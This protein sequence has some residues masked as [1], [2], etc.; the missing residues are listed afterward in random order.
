MVASSAALDNEDDEILFEGKLWHCRV[1]SDAKETWSQAQAKLSLTGIALQIGAERTFVELSPEHYVGDST[2]RQHGF[3]LS[4]LEDTVY[5]AAV[6]EATK[7]KWMQSLATALRKLGTR[8]R[9]GLSGGLA[10]RGANAGGP[11]SQRPE[12]QAPSAALLELRALEEQCQ[13]ALAWLDDCVDLRRKAKK[14]ADQSLTDETER[15]EREKAEKARLEREAKERR[16]EEEKRKCEQRKWEEQQARIRKLNEDRQRK[17]QEEAEQLIARKKEQTERRR[18]LPRAPPGGG[19]GILSRIQG[20][21]NKLD[22]LQN[23]DKSNPFSESYEGP[24]GPRPGQDGYG[25]A[26]AGSKTAERAAKAQEWVDKEID[27]F[28]SV[29]KDIGESRPDG[30][31][32]VTFGKLFVTYQDISDTL[33]G[34]MMRAKKRKHIH[35]EGDM[36]F[37]GR[38]NDVLVTLLPK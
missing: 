13:R 18:S 6:T 16:E 34:I 29:V 12:I 33:V 27:K 7:Q 20:W 8:E 31:T 22:G 23:A 9:E 11:H 36:L 3:L 10:L 21:N 25:C 38:D 19:G 17:Q 5:F 30:S 1:S 28:V 14:R 2:K 4:D 32:V 24:S 37:Q 15:L 26:K 35:Y